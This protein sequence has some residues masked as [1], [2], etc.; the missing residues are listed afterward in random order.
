MLCLPLPSS[1]P[2][3]VWTWM[4]SWN[5]GEAASRSFTGWGGKLTL[6]IETLLLLQFYLSIEQT[7]QVW[8]RKSAER[9]R[10]FS[11][12]FRRWILLNVVKT[13]NK[14][15][16]DILKFSWISLDW[17][18]RTENGN[19]IWYFESTLQISEPSHFLVSKSSKIF[20]LQ[21]FC[22]LNVTVICALEML[23]N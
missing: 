8:R 20:S 19:K 21:W 1:F 13:R 4:R 10:T 2:E 7:Q 3:W 23:H 5:S 15:T 6:A 17:P 11:V 9:D 16:V 14:K 18:V 12:L 22:I